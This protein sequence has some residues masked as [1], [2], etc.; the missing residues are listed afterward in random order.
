MS[1]HRIFYISLLSSI[2]IYHT[3]GNWQGV[4]QFH[5]K[6]TV[7]QMRGATVGRSPVPWN[8]DGTTV[9]AIPNLG[10]AFVK[11]IPTVN[12]I[13]NR[14]NNHFIVNAI[15]NLGLLLNLTSK[16]R[17]KC[18]MIVCDSANALHSFTHRWEGRP[19]TSATSC[20]ACWSRFRVGQMS[21]KC[22]PN[23]Q[24]FSKSNVCPYVFGMF[25]MAGVWLVFPKVI[26]F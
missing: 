21:K 6:P 17:T 20:N 11:T 9:N 14:E 18:N 2:N 23:V 12:A 19:H 24:Q 22:V 4:G 3:S 7:E 10:I 8:T 25:W 15:P 5:R 1:V 26:N 13:P 16:N